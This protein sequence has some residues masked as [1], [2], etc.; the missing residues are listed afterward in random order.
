LTP[1]GLIS[2]SFSSTKMTSIACTS[3]FTGTDSRRDY[4]S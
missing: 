4:G 3:A 1:S 2:S